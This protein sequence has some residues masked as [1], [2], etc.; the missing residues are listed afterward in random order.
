M[1]RKS[2]PKKS[3]GQN[4]LIDE[5][6][7]RKIVNAFK[8]R[9]DDFV[10]EIGPGKG[11]ITKY[12]EQNTG[13][14]VAVELD[15]DNCTYLEKSMP[16]LKLIN[17]D[18]LKTDLLKLVKQFDTHNKTENWVPLI[19]VIGN[20]PY[21]ITSEILFKLIDNRSYLKDA[22]LMIQ[23]EVAQRLVAEPDSKIYGITS[24]FTQVFTNPK[25]LFKVSKNCFFPKTGV[26]SRL[27]YFEFNNKLENDIT[28]LNLFKKTVRLSFGTRRKTLKNSLSK[29]GFGINNIDFDFSRRAETL[30]VSEFIF[31]SNQFSK[32]K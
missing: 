3:L 11:A 20:I 13:N 10:I 30:S 24:V 28:D 31:L 27:I 29:I 14:F 8:I 18:F 12:I 17:A 9:K 6:I 15:E 4:Y 5:N 23:E 16:G 32:C 2:F 7:S 21:N 19:R 25:L 26:D 22:L 1:T